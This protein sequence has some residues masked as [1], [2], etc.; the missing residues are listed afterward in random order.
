MKHGI[1][2]EE[3]LEANEGGLDAYFI[4]N[5]GGTTKDKIKSLNA[6]F[7]DIDAGKEG[8]NYYT[9]DKLKDIKLQMIERIKQFPLKPTVI[10]ETRN[11]YH[12]YWILRNRDKVTPKEWEIVQ[13][14]LMSYFDTVGSDKSLSKTNQL[15][16]LPFTNWVKGWTGLPPFYVNVLEN[17]TTTYSLDDLKGILE[18]VE[19]YKSSMPKV[20]YGNLELIRIGKVEELSKRVVEALKATVEGHTRERKNSHIIYKNLYSIISYMLNVSNPRKPYIVS[21]KEEFYTLT[22]QLPLDVLLGLPLQSKFSCIFHDDN[23]P[24]ANIWVDEKGRYWYKC[25][26]SCCCFTG[27]I[28]K[29]ISKI[30]NCDISE[31]INFIKRVFN[32]EYES[33]WQ[34]ETKERILIYEDYILSDSFADGYP[35]LYQFMKYHIPKLKAL[36]EIGRSKLID[37]SL[38]GDDSM[39]FYSSIEYLSA[40]MVKRGIKGTSDPSALNKKLLIFTQLGLIQRVEEGSIPPDLLKRLK[41]L[42]GYRTPDGIKHESERHITLYTIPRFTTEL[43]EEAQRRVGTFK[44]SNMTKTH[45]SRAMVISAQGEAIAN[46]IY[47]QSTGQGISESLERFY[48]RFRREAERL[49]S[50][51]GYFTEKQIVKSI[52]GYSAYIKGM[53]SKQCLPRLLRELDLKA[54]TVNND[55]REKYN[56]TNI[57]SRSVIYVKRI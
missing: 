8:N 4:P 22:S 55:S 14:K 25:F 21:T 45:Y 54:V 37:Q 41:E 20:P 43:L 29:V 47:V 24:S 11:G 38:L 57:A 36:L 9:E 15:M 1:S 51:N 10:V 28:I 56:I 48:S 30:R 12:L 7:M 27:D 16:R 5:T 19:P 23:T 26:G 13:R 53:Q 44:G 49:L 39:T 42:S 40:E 3:A 34:K 6:C 32:I 17:N 2:I 50:C 52:R 33:E 18:A 31:A 35:E 46:T